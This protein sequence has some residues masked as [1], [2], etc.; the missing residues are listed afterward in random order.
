MLRPRFARFVLG[1]ASVAVAAAVALTVLV[2]QPVAASG[3]ALQLPGDPAVAQQ[4]A[5]EQALLDL[6]NA[7]RVSNGVPAL[8]FDPETLSIARARATSQLGTATLTHYDTSGNLAFVTLL[9]SAGLGYR[10]AGE[11]LARSSD[12]DAGVTQRIEDALMH[13][14][15]HRE[16][17]LEPT[18]SRVAIGS[19]TDPSGQITFAEVYRS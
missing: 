18:F 8:Q 19:A 4:F 6:T 12:D 3:L 9:A 16:N 2:S 1:S 5:V 14:P 17:I 15:K 13:S 10:L 7:D 11:N